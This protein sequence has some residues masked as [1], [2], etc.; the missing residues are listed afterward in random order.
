MFYSLVSLK[1]KKSKLRKGKDAR[2]VY[3]ISEKKNQ[4]YKWMIKDLYFISGL[5]SDLVKSS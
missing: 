4:K 3:L 1:G 5:E 2:F